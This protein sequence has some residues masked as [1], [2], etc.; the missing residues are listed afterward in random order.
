[1][2]PFADF[3]SF[4]LPYAPSCPEP[5]AIQY[6]RQ[7]SIDFCQRT[8]FWR[9]VDEF[10]VAGDTTEILAVPGQASLFEI[11]KA[12]FQP[13][14]E[15]RWLELRKLPYAEIDQALLDQEANTYTVPNVISQIDYNTVTL[16]PR[17]SGKLRISMFLSPSYDASAC[18]E[19]LYS[20]YAS[21][22][23]DGALSEILMLPDQPFTNPNLAALKAG[24]FNAE[25]DRNFA[26][27]VRGQQRA[28]ARAKSSFM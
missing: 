1:M 14:S 7:A 5:V 28:P 2:R 12:W 9:S 22:I 11:E 24:V 26:L 3:L 4:V 27:N 8:R 6:V 18:P 21:T 15:S 17:A 19:N 25:C 20:N 23:A 13:T 16:V 10:D